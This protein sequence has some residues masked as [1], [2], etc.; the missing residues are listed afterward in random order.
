LKLKLIAA[1]IAAALSVTGVASAS[2]QHRGH[3]K[4]VQLSVGH[5]IGNSKLLSSAS[6]YIGL[7]K[8]AI[9]AQLKAG[10]SLS[11]VAVAQGKTEAGLVAALVAPAKLKLDAAVAAGR[12]TAE[13]EASF[14]TRLQE[15]VTKIVQR[16]VTPKEE[17]TGKIRISA[18]AILQPALAYLG[19]D[20]KA[21]VAQVVS[22]KS[23]ADVA[24]AQGKTASGLVDAIVASVKTKL[25]AQVAAGKLTAAQEADFLGKLQTS[26][27]A[28]VNG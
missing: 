11:E 4:R 21:L 20:L 23:L 28:F 1:G 8:A 26:V 14:L 2:N 22:G 12:L 7:D 6:V 27:T 24:V 9:V 5:Y 17:R 10:K 18:Q 15:K 3:G 19:L 13:R 25:D 16:K